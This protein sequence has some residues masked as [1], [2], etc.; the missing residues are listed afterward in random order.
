[1]TASPV[2]IATPLVIGTTAVVAVLAATVMFLEPARLLSL[3]IAMLFL[4]AAMTAL[5]FVTRRM[6]NRERALKLGGNLR[7]GRCQEHTGADQPRA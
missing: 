2:R 1:M 4:P 7:E 3:I 5:Y 6:Q